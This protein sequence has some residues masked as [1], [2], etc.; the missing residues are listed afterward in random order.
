[1]PLAAL[2]GVEI[3][4]E[5]RD[6]RDHARLKEIPDGVP[7]THGVL[8]PIACDVDDGVCSQRATCRHGLLFR[9]TQ[10]SGRLIA[11]GCSEQ[12]GAVQQESCVLV[13]PFYDCP[14]DEKILW[15]AVR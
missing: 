6:E 15:A 4:V 8:L 5:E 12:D 13:L 2:G 3:F 9:R 7:A 14:R 10:L 1:M 11:Q